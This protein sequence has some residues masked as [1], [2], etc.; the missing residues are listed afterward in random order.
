MYFST[1]NS[2]IL[3]EL[4]CHPQFL[5]DIIF[6]NVILAKFVSL[7]R[8]QYVLNMAEVLYFIL[9]I[10]W[11]WKRNHHKTVW[12]QSQTARLCKLRY[13][14]ISCDIKIIGKSAWG[15]LH[16]LWCAGLLCDNSQVLCFL[17]S[18]AFCIKGSCL[19]FSCFYHAKEVFNSPWH[20]LLSD[21][22]LTVHRNSVWIRKTN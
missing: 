10:E 20:L 7:S 2:S 17:F 22:W 11:A 5:C 8:Y 4:L 13:V 19:C 15:T 9:N 1:L 21:V 18:E 3:L 12:A 14:Q 16:C 6:L